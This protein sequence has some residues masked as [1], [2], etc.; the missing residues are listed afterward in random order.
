MS[1]SVLFDRILSISV[2]VCEVILVGRLISG[3]SRLEY[4]F[5]L[6]TIISTNKESVVSELSKRISLRIL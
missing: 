1:E 6:G 3:H 5:P 4:I 2:A